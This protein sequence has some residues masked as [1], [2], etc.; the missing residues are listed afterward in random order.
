MK[1]STYIGRKMIFENFHISVNIQ[2]HISVCRIFSLVSKFIH[3]D[4]CQESA[5]G[6]PYI[7]YTRARSRTGAPTR[8]GELSRAEALLVQVLF[9]C[10][11]QNLIVMTSQLS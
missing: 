8:I 4:E 11:N 10:T 3:R 1:I 9:L 7:V 6:V 5:N 2:C